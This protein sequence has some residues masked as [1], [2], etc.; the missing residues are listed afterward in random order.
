MQTL[1][2]STRNEHKIT[3]MRQ[4]LG[5]NYILHSLDEIPGF[6]DVEET[7]ATFEENAILKA[8]AASFPYEGF[9]IADDSGLEVDAL[10]GAPGVYSARFAGMAATSEEN[11]ALLLAKLQGVR[12]QNRSARFRCVIAVAKNGCCLMTF[13][14]TIEGYILP[15]AKGA[16]GFGYDPLFVPKGYCKTFA[17]LGSEMKNQLSHRGQALDKL[18]DWLC[19]RT[20]EK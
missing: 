15:K 6:L 4:I 11:N 12:G 10:Q 18:G 1:L 13:H 2:I 14:G 3:E 19:H 20:V 5:Q 17:Q 8:V 16:G 9:V 7:G